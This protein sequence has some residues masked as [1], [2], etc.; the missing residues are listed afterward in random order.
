KTQDFALTLGP[1][2]LRD[3][4][5]TASLDV[6][7]AR[8]DLEDL[9]LTGLG[10]GLSGRGTVLLRKGTWQLRTT[11]KDAQLGTL[12]P[13]LAGRLN[14]TA[15][16]NGQLSP[17]TGLAVLDVNL[18]RH[19]RRRRDFLPSRLA[20]RGTMHIG[21]S[22]VDLA[23]L[24]VFADGNSA[25][26]R[27]SINIPRRRANVFLALDLPRLGRW[28]AVRVGVDPVR[29]ARGRLHVTG[30]WPRLVAKGEVQA[31]G[32]GV[33]D[34]RLPR[35]GA[36][37]AFS[38]GTLHLR[39][40]T[41]HGYGGAVR[42]SGHLD[43]FAGGNLLKP[44][45]HPRLEARI[46]AKNLTLET[47]AKKPKLARGRLTAIIDVKGPLTSLKGVAEL[48]ASDLFLGGQRYR[49]AAARVG[50]LADRVSVYDA[51]LRRADGG[52]LRVWNDVFL[53]GR[54]ALSARLTDM[55]LTAIP[56]FSQVKI[57]VTGRV[58]GG[59]KL[60]GTL[61]DPRPA[62]RLALSRAIVRGATL[63]SGWL[64]FVPKNDTVR[65]EGA[66]FNQLIRIEGVAQMRPI[67]RLS[68][69]VDVNKFP[70]HR[71]F[72]ELSK[73]G[74]IRGVVSGRLSADLDEKA[75]LRAVKA[76]LS[77]VKFGLRYRP[78][79]Q[80]SY[81][82]LEIHN[83][84]DLAA[85]YDGQ[86]IAL[87]QAKLV[88]A[89]A[90]DVKVPRARFSAKGFLGEKTSNLVLLGDVP[91][92]LAE[93]F[94]AR[95]V[96]RIT[97]RAVGEVRVT[98]PM[99][100]LVPQGRLEVS[101]VAIRLPRFDRA[102]EI[103]TAAV[104][105]TRKAL[106]FER[107]ALKVGK[108]QLRVRGKVYGI[109]EIIDGHLEDGRYDLNLAGVFN[110]RLL[111]LFFPR[112]FSMASGSA[113]VAFDLRGPLTDPNLDGTVSLSKQHRVELRPRGLGRTITLSSGKIRLKRYLLTTVKPLGGTYDDGTLS[114]SG[115]A[116][117][118]HHELVDIYVHFKGRGIPQRK[119]KVY[120]AEM[121]VDLT[122]VGD[123]SGRRLRC[124]LSKI[125]GESQFRALMLTGTVDI[126]DA[127]YTREFDVVKNAVIKPRV[128]E[129]DRPF[130]EGNRA[131]ADLGLCLSVRTTGQM[132]VKNRYANLG[133]EMAMSV[134]GTLA[135][136]SVDGTVRVEEGKFS[137]PFLRGDYKVEHGDIAF[138]E[139]KDPG[140]ADLNIDA[141]T[142]YVD[143][144]G[145]AYQIR[146][147][148]KGP[149]DGILIKLSSQPVLDQGQILALL[150]TGRTTDQLRNE[151]NQN[152]GQGSAAGAADAQVKA[153]SGMVLSSILED[154]IKQVTGLD[155]VR[156]E[157]GTE[158]LTAK[159]CKRIGS[160]EI[161]GEYE[162][163]LLG[164]YSG[165]GS[166][167]YR[168]HDYLRLVGRLERLS[169]RFER[170]R[171]NPSRARIEL[172]FSFPLR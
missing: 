62:G 108:R 168:L 106:A 89:V 2:K 8:A 171:E 45:R 82:V 112:V 34:L 143:R 124:P 50:L 51:H 142:E 129:E 117:F 150:A 141:E 21:T 146:L 46:I 14:G 127:R 24:T 145:T 41:A 30:R 77:L 15:T 131:I 119:P 116:R 167:R 13:A 147:N 16:L 102:L 115:E 71:V 113:S 144:S 125:Q 64:R 9:R 7:K 75:G 162:K 85:T 37:I 70:V 48:S 99:I 120:A 110:A 123:P 26:V 101:K 58:S 54:L 20:V 136:P 3:I 80:R 5:A 1:L 38:Q 114:L 172:R 137:I 95:R 126:V 105:L 94:L 159:G 67:H 87:T 69:T 91:L 81:R 165:K 156:L 151:L 61:T 74:D 22:V 66:L 149:L 111:R 43:L 17:L 132:K 44:R 33:G 158:T 84:G 56:G 86:R 134:M 23:G 63:G 170:E 140:K 35:V 88:S 138:S 154:P 163:D 104:T 19:R 133:L 39:K 40:I 135:N 164:G 161:C 155:L 25:R 93:F 68:V 42:G 139:G 52:R 12:V 28:L 160:F 98:G 53:D 166:A 60:L 152:G 72:P 29:S 118:D 4:S 18:K 83:E 55:P 130:W 65:I 73:L 169:T 148:L 90:H 79:G 57:P 128:Y 76:R 100:Q 157:I 10:G 78:L 6:A 96:K 11:V 121:N 32:V 59:L 153:L 47:L 92:E 97:G 27:G 122:L 103:P 49:S 107:F 36:Q 109:D 31:K